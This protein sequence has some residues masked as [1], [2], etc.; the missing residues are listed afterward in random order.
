MSI[1]VNQSERD[2]NSYIESVEEPGVPVKAVGNSDGTRLD[3][4]LH[5]GED[6]TNNVQKVEL[7]G[8][9]ILVS[10]D[11]L[12]KSGSGLLYAVIFQCNDSAPTAGNID[13]YD[14]TTNSG[15]KLLSTAITTTF[16]M[17]DPVPVNGTF[18]TGLYIDFTTTADVNVTLIYR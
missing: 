17:P 8:T 5:A 13:I 16:F 14:N 4:T 6:L 9:P 18:S 1:S 11:T 12:I 15:T 10:T 2:I 7:R 3:S